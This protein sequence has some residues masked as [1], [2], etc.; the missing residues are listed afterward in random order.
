M[1]GQMN[2]PEAGATRLDPTEMFPQAISIDETLAESGFERPFRGYQ[3]LAFRGRFAAHV[4]KDA[5]RFLLLF[6]RQVQLAF[7]I[8]DMQRTGHAIQ[9]GRL[10]QAPAATALQFRN[11]FDRQTFDG[12]ML[13]PGIGRRMDVCALGRSR[14]WHQD[15]NQS[16]HESFHGSPFKHSRSRSCQTATIPNMIAVMFEEIIV[17]LQT[18]AVAKRSFE[19][20]ENL[21][22][23]GD[24]V[25]AL[26]LVSEG[27]VN[28]V[29]Y[30]EDGSPAVLQRSGDLSILAEAS[31]F[32]DHYH[33]DA[34]VT[35]KT[36]VLIV[37]IATVRELLENEPAFARVWA[38]HLSQELQSARKRAEI[39][40]LRTVRA[41]LE[42]WLTWNEGLPMKGGWRGLAEELGVSPEALYRE[43]S[44]RRSVQEE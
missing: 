36:N 1:R 16:S 14:K 28:L 37:P 33:C 4:L 17:H 20:N 12:S 2:I 19:K 40:S 18:K 3:S 9:L 7:H 39:A 5:G 31:V 25:I 10:R 24:P 32:S 30:Q 26:Y 34:V 11:V 13:L 27:S 35:K 22:H 8:Q 43:L 29:R 42:A 15:R 41:R 23:R 6:D 44:S 21:F 38:K